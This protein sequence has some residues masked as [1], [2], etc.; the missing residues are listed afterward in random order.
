MPAE[1]P[2]VERSRGKGSSAVFAQ[3]EGRTRYGTKLSASRERTSRVPSRGVL[4]YITLYDRGGL[5]GS[6]GAG[7]GERAEERGGKEGWPGLGPTDD[8]LCCCV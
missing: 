2:G 3:Q 8:G 7:D 5:R 6:A 1:G 4:V